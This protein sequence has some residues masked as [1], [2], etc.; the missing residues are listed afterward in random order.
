MSES[1]PVGVI[2]RPTAPHRPPIAVDP[3]HVDVARARG[4]TFFQDASALVD[5]REDHALDNLLLTDRPPVDTEPSRSLDDN[6]FDLRVGHRC[7]R[8][9]LIAEIPLPGLLTE[10]PGFAKRILYQ[11]ALAPPFADAPTDIEPSEIHHRAR[12]HRKAERN[13][14]SIDLLG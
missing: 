9:R 11:R 7:A 13:D 1:Q 12:P 10:M 5:H 6:P 2:H 3:D 14:G 4:D 8:P